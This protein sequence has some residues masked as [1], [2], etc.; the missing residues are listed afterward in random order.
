[1]NK[2]DRI[3]EQLSAYIDGELSP[4]QMQRVGEAVEA[5]AELAA[6]LESLRAV[7]ELLRSLP[8]ARAPGDLM[9]SILQQAERSRLVAAPAP[10]PTGALRWFRRF[11]IAAILAIAACI[12][13]AIVT[14]LWTVPAA[15]T[16]AGRTGPA[17]RGTALAKNDKSEHN[18]QPG[19]YARKKYAV[20]AASA[21]S[22]APAVANVDIYTG[23]LRAVQ[24]DVE[25][26]LGANSIK[27]A[28]RRKSGRKA[29]AAFFH[30]R[31]LSAGQVQ[32]EIY[33]TD[34]QIAAVRKELG[35]V[36]A[37]QNAPRSF[38]KALRLSDS[39]ASE[40]SGV[41][42]QDRQVA[43]ERTPATSPSAE[44]PSKPS[45]FL[46]VLRGLFGGGK[47]EK[48]RASS[49]PASRPGEGNG[50]VAASLP[51]S[52]RKQDKKQKAQREQLAA[53]S[54]AVANNQQSRLLITLNYRG[55][56]RSA[57]ASRPSVPAVDRA[58]GN[59]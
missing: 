21:P 44:R 7:R 55:D 28:T 23:D 5:D 43:N 49:C 58:R 22:S 31:R 46:R 59:R 34:D 26:I 33:A 47:A 42:R 8:A 53:T 13:A 40:Y 57:P 29:V 10:A 39:D 56:A 12:G 15:P 30:A 3:R 32:Y 54:R 35:P 25:R 36:I 52:R 20:V 24:R 16:T 4:S 1:M 2:R 50:P 18:E 17:G 11:A 38:V 27:P 45:P 6:E 48:K 37:T 19:G 41:L 51:A 14:Q 9:D